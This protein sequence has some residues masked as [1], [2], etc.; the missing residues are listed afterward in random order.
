M[1]RHVGAVTEGRGVDA[2]RGANPVEGSVI[3]KRIIVPDDVKMIIMKKARGLS[4]EERERVT[5][6]INGNLQVHTRINQDGLRHFGDARNAVMKL[7]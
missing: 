4:Y 7:L 6:W 2:G 3:G 1:N 5:E